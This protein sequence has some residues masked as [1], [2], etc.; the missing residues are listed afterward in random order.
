MSAD[1]VWRRGEVEVS[2]SSLNPRGKIDIVV[3]SKSSRLDDADLEINVEGDTVIGM[4][5]VSL[6]ETKS[7]H[8]HL[9]KGTPPTDH[10]SGQP[11]E[12][13]LLAVNCQPVLVLLSAAQTFK[14]SGPYLLFFGKRHHIRPFIYFKCADVLTTKSDIQ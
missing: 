9:A 8:T 6:G 1:H 11:S 5:D 7:C 3:G 10:P 14:K 13:G 4:S 12:V 2:S